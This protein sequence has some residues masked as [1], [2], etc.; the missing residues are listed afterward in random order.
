MTENKLTDEQITKA[1]KCCC[2]EVHELTDG[3]CNGCPMDKLCDEDADALI[4]YALDLINRQKAEIERLKAEIRNT[5]NILNLLDRPLVK[6]KSEAIKAFAER[7]RNATMPVT[8]G[9]KYRYDVITKEGIDNLV[10]EMEG[11]K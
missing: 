4:K 5:D 11:L 3:W 10:K 1:L 7:L 8:L 9:G 2:K 6:V